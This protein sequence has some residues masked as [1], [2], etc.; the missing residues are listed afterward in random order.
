M[1]MEQRNP[2]AGWEQ[3]KKLMRT[4]RLPWEDDAVGT[5]QLPKPDAR[6]Y[7]TLAESLWDAERTGRPARR[8]GAL[9]PGLSITDAYF[10]RRE[11]DL[12]RMAHG[13]VPVG[14]KIGLASRELLE[15]SG[16]AEPYWAYI[17]NSGQARNGATLDLRG[18]RR[19]LLEPEI[20]V[21]LGADLD[22][23]CVTK[24]IAAAA[25]ERLHPALE[26]VDIRTDVEGLVVEEAIADSGWNAGFVLGEGVSAAGIDLDTVSVRV[27]VEPSGDVREGEARTLLDGPAGCLAWL[28]EQ[29]RVHGEPLRAGEVVLTGTL[30]GAIPLTPGVT[31][32]AAFTGLGLRPRVARVSGQ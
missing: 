15:R 29:L 7:N 23:P 4:V 22:Q 27:H 25:I 12:M 19:P 5:D 18:L 24:A 20:A 10:I 21:V 13:S 31:V 11:V 8:L 28:A 16:A 17:F 6:R 1:V 30:T 26:I 14:R 32:S 2:V 3:T 9:M